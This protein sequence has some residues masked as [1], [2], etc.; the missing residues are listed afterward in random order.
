MMQYKRE[1]GIII[2]SSGLDNRYAAFLRGLT[3]EEFL[4]VAMR[5]CSIEGY[6]GQEREITEAEYRR[7]L[8][9]IFDR[10]GA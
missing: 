4:L 8:S 6:G 5:H 7:R 2:G 3:H 1:A 10:G 9:A